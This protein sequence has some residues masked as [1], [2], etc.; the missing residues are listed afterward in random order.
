MAAS[1]APRRVYTIIT[2]P[3]NGLDGVSNGQKWRKCRGRIPDGR[4]PVARQRQLLCFF[5]LVGASLVTDLARALRLR[6]ETQEALGFGLGR[7]RA[8]V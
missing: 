3:G 7:G 8:I 6:L 2:P 5:V 4:F 1:A